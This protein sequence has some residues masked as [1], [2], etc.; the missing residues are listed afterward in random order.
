MFTSMPSAA[1]GV[2]RRRGGTDS[3]EQATR[4]CDW[5]HPELIGGGGVTGEGSGEWRR[6]GRSRAPA[7]T[8]FPA[9]FGAGKI[10]T[11]TWE[12][13]WDLGKG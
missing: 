1:G 3:D 8:R 7:A 13:E 10:N 5:P 2:R 6:Q 9:R 4:P 12:L 11:R